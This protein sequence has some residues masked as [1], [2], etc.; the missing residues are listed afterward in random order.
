MGFEKSVGF[1]G[2]FLFLCKSFMRN[3]FVDLAG[4]VPA[5]DGWLTEISATS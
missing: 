1:C 2:L 3:N 5:R 4:S